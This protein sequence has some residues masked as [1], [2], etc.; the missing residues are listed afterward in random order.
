MA[1]LPERLCVVKDFIY[2][3]QVIWKPFMIC[4]SGDQEKSCNYKFWF[5][6]S[7]SQMDKNYEGN[8]FP[9]KQARIIKT[10]VATLARSVV[11]EMLRI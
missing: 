4:R 11:G 8:P 5:L 6:L 10:K 2:I 3:L 1:I 7:K 9:R